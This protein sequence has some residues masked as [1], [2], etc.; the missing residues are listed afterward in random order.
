[1]NARLQG[2]KIKRIR[3]ENVSG[4]PGLPCAEDPQRWQNAKLTLK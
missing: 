4:A 1:M 2:S 3:V